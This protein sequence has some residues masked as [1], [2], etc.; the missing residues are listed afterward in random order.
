MAF[1]KLIIELWY[2]FFHLY[3]IQHIYLMC[4]GL[5]VPLKL[6]PKCKYFSG[7]SGKMSCN[8]YPYIAPHTVAKYVY[9]LDFIYIKITYYLGRKQLNA[10][11]LSR[12]RLSPVA[13][14]IN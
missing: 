1:Y 7:S 11:W 14:E 8:I 12:K 9:V 4:G 10:K 13:G 3:R 6:C 2:L 5:L